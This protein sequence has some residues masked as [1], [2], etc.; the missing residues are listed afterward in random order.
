M[1]HIPFNERR[2]SLKDL[3]IS[4][5]NIYKVDPQLKIVN[6]VL[7]SLIDN[8]L[9]LLE[10]ENCISAALPFDFTFEKISLELK[11]RATSWY[12]VQ[13]L[14]FKLS[15]IIHFS[16]APSSFIRDLIKDGME[17]I[18]DSPKIINTL[19]SGFCPSLQKVLKQ[20]N[21]DIIEN[22]NTKNIASLTELL[23]ISNKEMDEIINYNFKISKQVKDLGVSFTP[24]VFFKYPEL[25]KFGMW[26]LDGR[27]KELLHKLVKYPSEFVK[28]MNKYI[29]LVK[30]EMFSG[31]LSN[32][33]I[34]KIVDIVKINYI[35]KIPYQE[36]DL[37][38]CSIRMFEL[39]QEYS[40]EIWKINDLFIEAISLFVH[41]K[42]N[43]KV[44]PKMFSAF[45]WGLDILEKELSP[46]FFDEIY[47]SEGENIF[48]DASISIY[49]EHVMKGICRALNISQVTFSSLIEHFENKELKCT[50]DVLSGIYRLVTIPKIF[51]VNSEKELIHF[52]RLMTNN[53]T[54]HKY[55]GKMIATPWSVK[56]KFDYIYLL[57]EI[58]LIIGFTLKNNL[59]FEELYNYTS[60]E[61]FIT[62]EKCKKVFINFKK[63]FGIKESKEFFITEENEN[64]E[65]VLDKSKTIKDICMS[66]KLFTEVDTSK[67]YFINPDYEKIIKFIHVIKKDQLNDFCNVLK[68]KAHTAMTLSER[69]GMI[70]NLSKFLIVPTSGKVTSEEILAKFKADVEGH[71]L[72]TVMEG[73]NYLISDNY[74]N[75]IKTL[76]LPQ[77]DYESVTK[78]LSKELNIYY[79]SEELDS[80]FSRV[81][82]EINIPEKR[83]SKTIKELLEQL[84]CVNE[85]GMIVPDWKYKIEGLDIKSQFL[86]V[87]TIS[88]YE[89]IKPAD[90]IKYFSH[91]FGITENL[92]VTILLIYENISYDNEI[93]LAQ[94]KEYVLKKFSYYIAQDEIKVLNFIKKFVSLTEKLNISEFSLQSLI[95]I[96]G[97]LNQD[98]R[99]QIFPSTIFTFILF[100]EILKDLEI[101]EE[102]FFHKIKLIFNEN[103]SVDELIKNVIYSVRKDLIM[104]EALDKIINRL[105]K[106]GKSDYNEQNISQIKKSDLIEFISSIWCIIQIHKECKKSEINIDTLFKMILSSDTQQL[107]K[108]EIENNL[109]T[110][111][112]KLNKN[113]L[114]E[115]D[116]LLNI[117]EELINEVVE[118]FVSHEKK[119]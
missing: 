1:I 119:I 109:Q 23:G 36:L 73:R 11:D 30:D 41:F 32:I 5:D 19:N 79:S 72:F 78:K 56:S 70:S 12:N 107:Y 94:E 18:S 24:Y 80:V 74:E 38:I 117:S 58:E 114:P 100:N 89:V 81:F 55:M 35:L 53:R 110:A 22:E 37:L 103:Y 50:M 87:N 60:E 9:E 31:K 108:E 47:N 28:D 49:D 40:E 33:Y 8:K 17:N 106:A 34:Q 116:K 25:K 99:F 76:W 7:S 14:V 46:S 44:T 71:K 101:S 10:S 59:S 92:F 91:Y 51:G 84:K 52:Y 69:D 39:K 88:K 75:I 68:E 85:F 29:S 97:V 118:R 63:Q 86:L 112:F 113:P 102:E 57:K 43:Y 83:F 66:L 77:N 67:L 95:F 2:P 13:N 42:E 61:K 6:E 27:R 62:D 48:I 82:N 111:K 93:T 98:K 54:F 21:T 96:G 64:L 105:I 4:L 20:D 15:K 90:V 104:N 16:G 26:L 65:R 45:F 115:G 3:T